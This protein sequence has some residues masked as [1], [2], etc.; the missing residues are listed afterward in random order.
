MT[1]SREMPQLSADQLRALAEGEAAL[2]LVESLMLAMIE[3]GLIG[4][5]R[6]VEAVETVIETKRNLAERD[7]HPEISRPAVGIVRALANSIAAAKQKRG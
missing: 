5:E 1:P 7:Q 3:E 2:M 4:R 6:V